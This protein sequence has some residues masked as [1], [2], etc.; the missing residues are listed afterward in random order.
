MLSA[1]NE[2]I[3]WPTA[4][5]LIPQSATGFWGSYATLSDGNLRELWGFEARLERLLEGTNTIF[6]GEQ[7]GQG[8]R[9]RRSIRV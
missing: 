7:D 5:G 2:I 9:W 1:A 8:T 3:G 4:K 6:D